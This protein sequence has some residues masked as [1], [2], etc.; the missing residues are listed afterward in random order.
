[1]TAFQSQEY[2][3]FNL[4]ESDRKQGRLCDFTLFANGVC[5]VAHKV[6]LAAAIPFFREVF[7]HGGECAE[8]EELK[9][10]S[11]EMIEMIISFAYNGRIEIT[12]VNLVELLNV[13]KKLRIDKLKAPCSE[14][15]STR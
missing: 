10:L 2:R 7:L 13:A 8:F 4:L 5:I 11:P 9:R 14:Y 15:I 3:P 6:V 12:E 1:M